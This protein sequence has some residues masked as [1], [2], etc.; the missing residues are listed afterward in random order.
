MLWRG[1]LYLRFASGGRQTRLAGQDSVEQ[2][3]QR[4]SRG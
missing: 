2:S 4:R 1:K 3:L